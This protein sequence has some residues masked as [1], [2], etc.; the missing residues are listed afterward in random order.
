MPNNQLIGPFA[1]GN[2]AKV[3]INGRWFAQLEGERENLYTRSK[4]LDHGDWT[5]TRIASITANAETAP[6]GTLTAE[7]IIPN[8]DNDV[9][10]IFQT[11]TGDGSSPYCFS[12]FAKA[13]EYNGLTLRMPGAGFTSPAAT[14]YYN[15]VTGVAT[16]GDGPPVATGMESSSNGWFL[17]WIVAMSDSV[18]DLQP[19]IVP[20]NNGLASFAGDGSSGIYAWQAQPEIGGFPSSIIE[21][22]ATQETR[23]ADE[24]YLL[25]ADVPAYLRTS[26]HTVDWIPQAASTD[27]RGTQHLY[28]IHDL[29]TGNRLS[30]YWVSNDRLQV[31]RYDGAWTTLVQTD[32]L[33]CS[34]NQYMSVILDPAAGSIE[35]V[36]A[37]SGGDK[38]VGI[39]WN[40]FITTISNLYI[41]SNNSFA[42]N[43]NGLITPAY[44]TA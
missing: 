40:T 31:N 3:L 4:E 17:C 10:K 25:A 7:K 29:T 28:S 20:S 13:G 41:G 23:N 8:T 27:I 9:H 16:P 26:K 38:V 39:P 37:T 21:T 14:C 22:V 30:V 33:V 6:D 42:N 35:V 36:G 43:L 12:V 44:K 19:D 18:A 11:I 2:L 15:L 24:L 1:A 32:P 5:R 34:R